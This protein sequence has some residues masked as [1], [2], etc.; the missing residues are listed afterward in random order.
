[1]EFSFSIKKADECRMRWRTLRERF[2]RERKHKHG[3]SKWLLYDE[4]NF[5]SPFVKPRNRLHKKKTKYV[6]EINS[7]GSLFIDNSA[8]SFNDLNPVLPEAVYNDYESNFSESPND[9]NQS[10]NNSDYM[11]SNYGSEQA[12]GDVTDRSVIFFFSTNHF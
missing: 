1:M 7:N 8:S 11:I 4:I 10:D 12:N 6:N 2:A 9:D 5:I 3:Q